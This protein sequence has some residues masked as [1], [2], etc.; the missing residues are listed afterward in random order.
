MKC[1]AD[2]A[3]DKFADST[4]QAREWMRSAFANL[5]LVLDVFDIDT[6]DQLMLAAESDSHPEVDAVYDLVHNE[7]ALNSAVKDL[8]D[9]ASNMQAALTT[10]QEGSSPRGEPGSIRLKGNQP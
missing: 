8:K 4:E 7:R 3:D 1:Y 5:V 9:A 2:H 10:Y 6:M